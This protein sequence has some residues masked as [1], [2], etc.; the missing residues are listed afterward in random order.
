MDNSGNHQIPKTVVGQ[1]MK[2]N[3]PVE[4]VEKMKGNRI[5]G[6][7]GCQTGQKDAGFRLGVSG[8]K[9]R[10][11]PGFDSGVIDKLPGQSNQLLDF[12][13]VSGCPQMFDNPIAAIRLLNH[14]HLD[15]A[16]PA[17]QLSD[18]HRYSLTNGT[19]PKDTKLN[20]F[21]CLIYDKSFP[22]AKSGGM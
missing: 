9:K 19:S 18:E 14:L 8:I 10:N 11:S 5:I 12:K 22:L 4:V 21:L 1:P 3:Q 20:C 17:F 15:I 16:I 6:G 7:Q 2:T 13:I